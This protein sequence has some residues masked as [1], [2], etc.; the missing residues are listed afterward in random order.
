MKWI[1]WLPGWKVEPDFIIAFSAIGTDPPAP[2]G[3]LTLADGVWRALYN[4][5]MAISNSIFRAEGTNLFST[6]LN[7]DGI[8][9]AGVPVVQDELSCFEA[10]E[11]PCYA[12]S[13]EAS[14]AL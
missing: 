4:K 1:G 13:A 12:G 2:D 14:R 6:N 10:I 3:G 11:P 9:I 7:M 5:L 8:W